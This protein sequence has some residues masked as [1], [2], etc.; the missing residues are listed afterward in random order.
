MTILTKKT[1]NVARLHRVPLK[2]IKED[3]VLAL[4]ASLKKAKWKERKSFKVI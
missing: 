2:K 4:M 1:Y 3:I